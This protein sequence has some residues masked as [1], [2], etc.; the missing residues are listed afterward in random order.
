MQ[1]RSNSVSQGRDESVCH[2][3]VVPSA[4][5]CTATH[6]M[7]CTATH[8]MQ[9]TATHTMQCTATHT[10]QCTATH[11][12]Q[13]TASHTMQCTATHTMQCN[14]IHTTHRSTGI[15]HGSW[16]PM[17][18]KMLVEQRALWK[19]LVPQDDEGST[20]DVQQLFSSIAMLMSLQLRSLVL[21]SIEAFV[22]FLEEYAVGVCV[23][24]GVFFLFLCVCLC[25]FL[26]LYVCLFTTTTY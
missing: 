14:A 13:C 22:D 6:T 4:M 19:F 20:R 7:Q 8:T 12:I 18:A 3:R 17:V 23:C 21:K 25:V 5:Q 10:M 11:T 26:F 24:V 1:F 2:A 9:C 15:H 16:V